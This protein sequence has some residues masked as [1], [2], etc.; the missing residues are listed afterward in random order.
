MAKFHSGQRCMIVQTEAGNLGRIVTLVSYIGS[1]DGFKYHDWW[2]IQESINS[3]LGYPISIVSQA[4]LMPLD[5]AQTNTACTQT[6]GSLPD[7]EAVFTPQPIPHLKPYPRPPSA[8]KAN[9]WKAP[10]MGRKVLKWA[11]I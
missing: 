6:R 5:E 8:G 3:M 7:L 2:S 4:Q 10:Y 1:V 9:R 11:L